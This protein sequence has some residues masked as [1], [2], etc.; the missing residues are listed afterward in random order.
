[1]GIVAWGEGVGTFHGPAKD[2]A[3]ALQAQLDEADKIMK[4]L[5]LPP[6]D[7]GQSP[8]TRVVFSGITIDT[9]EGMLDIDEEQRTYVL[10][11]LQDIAENQHCDIKTLESVNGSLGWLCFVIHHGRCR[12]DMFQKA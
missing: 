3:T 1:M 4:K 5:G 7:K 11:R 2:G 6:N 10:Q 12:R 8:S 9:V